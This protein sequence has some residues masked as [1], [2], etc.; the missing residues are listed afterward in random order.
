MTHAVDSTKNTWNDTYKD[1][2]TSRPWRHTAGR[3]SCLAR[4]P[5]YLIGMGLQT[6]KIVVKAV[7]SPLFSLIAWAS[8]TAKL[9]SWTF[10]GVGRDC[11]IW[12]KLLDK[13]GSS[14]I[15]LLCAPPKQYYSFYEAVK[16]TGKQVILGAYHRPLDPKLNKHAPPC[17][18]LA[19][20]VF[21]H[22]P[23]YSKM[24]FEGRDI[25][26]CKT[27]TAGLR[28]AIKAG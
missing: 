10:S 7:F 13:I 12:V 2:T 27:L 4:I 8:G 3:I 9:D 16:G 19:Q 14:S 1:V 25:C 5:I 22:R 18:L 6:A 28:K 15:G 17:S 23:Q 26:S 24:V 21:E 11:L 20:M